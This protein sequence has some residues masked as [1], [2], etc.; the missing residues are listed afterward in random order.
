MKDFLIALILLAI[1]VPFVILFRF[2]GIPPWPVLVFVFYYSVFLR[3]D[4]TKLKETAIGALIG[5]AVSFS[6][7][8]IGLINQGLGE[9]VFLLL[10][11]AYF[12]FLLPG[13]IKYINHAG[14][15]Y[16]LCLTAIAPGELALGNL[17]P[18]AAGT[19]GA[20]LLFFVIGIFQRR[21]R[22][23]T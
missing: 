12:T 20:S 11:V 19:I 16:L 13:K 4:H 6:S 22:H 2:I 21:K 15:L 9:L 23:S 5:I 14:N 3:M 17:L 7:P 10:L 8:V 1:I 18:V